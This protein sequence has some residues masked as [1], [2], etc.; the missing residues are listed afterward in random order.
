M[1]ATETNANPERISQAA[2]LWDESD[3]VPGTMQRNIHFWRETLLR[4]HPDKDKP[5]NN[6]IQGVRTPARHFRPFSSLCLFRG[7]RYHGS[8]PTSIELPN[9]IELE[10]L[11]QKCCVPVK[12]TSDPP[13]PEMSFPLG[14]EQPLTTPH[15]TKHH[16][17]C[18]MINGPTSYAFTL[19]FKWTEWG[20]LLTARGKEHTRSHWTTCQVSTIPRYMRI[21]GYILGFS[22]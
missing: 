21:P 17:Y 15:K 19:P 12:G 4:N 20:R 18:G 2:P 22:G 11:E 3:F 6:W 16:A 7:H 8:E 14:I 5:P 13:R 10:Q 1:S 9:H